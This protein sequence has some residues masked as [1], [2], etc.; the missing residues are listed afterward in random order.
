ML[1]VFHDEFGELSRNNELVAKTRMA[2]S[3]K[4]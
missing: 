2:K 1:T 3:T 4:G